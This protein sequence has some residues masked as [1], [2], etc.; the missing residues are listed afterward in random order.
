MVWYSLA[1]LKKPTLDELFLDGRAYGGDVECHPAAGVAGR[2]H[3][4]RN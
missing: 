1:V 2:R 3:G 4:V